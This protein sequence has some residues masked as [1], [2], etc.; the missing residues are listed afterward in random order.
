MKIGILT[1]QNAHNWG[2]SLQAFA[3][4][5]YLEK[6][7]YEV[8]IIN[9]INENIQKNYRRSEKVKF[10]KS[11]LMS[12]PIYLY[13]LI[14]KAYTA[15]QIAEKW[16]MFHEFITQ[17]LLDGD[18]QIYTAEDI[19]NSDF[20]VMIY[21]SDQIWNPKL[22]NG[23]DSVYFGEGIKKARNISYAASMG[24]KKLEAEDEKKFKQYLANFDYLSVREETLKNYIKELTDKE[25]TNVVD[26]TLLIEQEEYLKIEVKPKIKDY[27]LL[28]EIS[29]NKQMMKIAKKI[30]KEKHLKIV[31]LEYKKDMK[32][33]HYKQIANVGPREFIG[34]L[35]SAKFVVTNSFHGTVFSILFEKDFYTIPINQSNSRMENLLNICHLKSRYIAEESEVDLES[36]IDFKTAKENIQQN[37]KKS[38]EFLKESLEGKD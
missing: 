29:P 14:Q 11:G 10:Q 9:Y 16:D 6:Q 21:G 15:K 13:Q 3:L 28:Y 33:M 30:A 36:K 2:A 32:K 37:R 26:P 35:R 19:Q 31:C 24:L 17:S 8:K 20:D 7:G 5:T 25:A 27:L 4:K 38:I 18:T 34:L 1:F 22:T 12:I 23:L